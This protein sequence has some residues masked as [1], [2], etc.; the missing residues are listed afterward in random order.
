MRTLKALGVK[1][2]AGDLPKSS[3]SDLEATVIDLDELIAN[4]PEAMPINEDARD[5]IDPKTLENE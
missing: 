2:W 4:Q 1:L 5:V 3:A